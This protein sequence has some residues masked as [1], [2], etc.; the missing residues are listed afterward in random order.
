MRTA[1]KEVAAREA[2]RDLLAQQLAAAQDDFV[3]LGRI[4]AELAMAEE[5]VA[6]AEDQWLALAGEL[7]SLS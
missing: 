7:E 6:A 5:L 4:G 2:A 3:A 1:A